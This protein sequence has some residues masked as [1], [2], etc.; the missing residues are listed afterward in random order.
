MAGEGAREGNN[1]NARQ[2]CGITGA[3]AAPFLTTH[4]AY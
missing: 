1:S 4:R 3:L 2:P